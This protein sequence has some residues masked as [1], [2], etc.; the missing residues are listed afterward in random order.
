MP[1]TLETVFLCVWISNWWRNTPH[2]KV[3]AAVGNIGMFDV[4]YYKYFVIILCVWSY[5]SEKNVLSC[6]ECEFV[7]G[8]IKISSP[9]FHMPGLL[10]YSLLHIEWH[11]LACIN[12]GCSSFSTIHIL[13]SQQ[14]M[15]TIG[16]DSHKVG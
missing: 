10:G 12:Q 4:Q 3:Q 2:I 11:L 5:L 9:V 7:F 15:F 14:A 13:Y 8:Y 16:K 1:G 6:H